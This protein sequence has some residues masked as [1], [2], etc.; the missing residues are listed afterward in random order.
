MTDCSFSTFIRN[1]VERVAPHMCDNWSEIVL[2]FFGSDCKYRLD[3]LTK[4][5]NTHSEMVACKSISNDWVIQPVIF[6]QHLTEKQTVVNV[7]INICHN[8]TNYGQKV[9][10]D[11]KVLLDDSGKVM[12]DT[13]ID[14]VVKNLAYIITSSSRL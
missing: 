8:G 7:E 9:I 6:F 12:F 10:M 1:E 5:V 2:H 13:Y 4:F 14:Q 11:Y 3:M